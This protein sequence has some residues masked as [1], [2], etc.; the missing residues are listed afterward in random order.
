M[1]EMTLPQYLVKNARE[2]PTASACREK[3]KG[4]WQEWSW[5][6][7]LAHVRA[8]ARG[9]VSLGFGR[10]DKLACG[11]GRDL[12]PIT[13]RYHPDK[14]NEVTL[15]VAPGASSAGRLEAYRR[16]LVSPR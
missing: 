8:F 6:D 7:Y 15:G 11:W 12:G 4:I 14:N 1:A 16:R 2:Y 13:L 9:L 5:A 10:D 3:E